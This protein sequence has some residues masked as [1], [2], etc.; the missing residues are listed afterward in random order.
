MNDERLRNMELDFIEFKASV[1]SA[2]ESVARRVETLSKEVKDM[3]SVTQ[4]I[5]IDATRI[6]TSAENT[7]KILAHHT[8]EDMVVFGQMRLDIKAVERTIWKA[9][10]GLAVVVFL[11]GFLWPLLK[12][13]PPEIPVSAK[14]HETSK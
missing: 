7:E 5:R 11:A 6:A 14:P 12:P 13:N 1:Q 8:V 10:G 4:S 9:A 3:Q 2:L